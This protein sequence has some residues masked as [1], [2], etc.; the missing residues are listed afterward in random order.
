MDHRSEA[1]S[2]V[3]ALRIAR[4]CVEEWDAM[5][6]V[7]G[8]ARDRVRHCA[9]CDRDVYAVSSMARDE[10]AAFLRARVGERTCVRLLR[11]DDGTVVTRDCPSTTPEQRRRRLHVFAATALLAT[12]IGVER[13]IDADARPTAP[14]L[15]RD[16]AVTVAPTIDRE[17]ATTVS[18]PSLAIAGAHNL[19]TPVP[20][21]LARPAP[22]R[23]V[24]KQPAKWGSLPANTKRPP[25]PTMGLMELGY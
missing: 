3:D 20:A 13:S 7:S 14:L 18:P 25:G 17:D 15:A 19:S 16:P 22:T 5:I 8:E 6:A 4:P 12:T 2:F 1:R 24:T 11:R 23:V 10:A 9:R 21:N